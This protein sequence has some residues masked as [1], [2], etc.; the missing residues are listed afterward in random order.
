[1]ATRNPLLRVIVTVACAAAIGLC[2]ALAATAAPD[3]SQPTAAAAATPWLVSAKGI[4]PV[5]LGRSYAGLKAD[6]LVGKLRPG[7]PLGPKRFGAKL[8]PPAKGLVTFNAHRHVVDVSVTAAAQTA[9]HATIGDTA[10]HVLALYPSARYIKAKPT[11]PIP[12]GVIQVNKKG[13]P[14]FS[15]LIDATTK[16]VVQL[17]APTAQFC[18]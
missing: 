4:G 8:R 7:C 13:K 2:A 9:K 5:T 14:Q 3:G 17:D 11:D 18:E 12:F 1:M 15:F 10:T 16:R 6:G